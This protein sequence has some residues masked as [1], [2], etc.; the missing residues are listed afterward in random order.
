MH[1]L[2]SLLDLQHSQFTE[3]LWRELETKFGLRGVYVTPFPHFSYQVAVDYDDEALEPILARIAKTSAP[4]KVTT[5]GLGIFTGPAPVLYIPI[6]VSQTLAQFH[7]QVWSQT[8]SA[9]SGALNY[10][11]PDHW[12]PHITLG[13]GDLKPEVLAQVVQYLA[14]RNFNRE[15]TVDNLAYIQNT[16]PTQPLRLKFTFG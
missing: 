6:V 1:G 16:T 8:V 11:H 9:S 7:R 15:I 12:M 5:S 13:L 10:Y 4:F 3:S 14:G 2:V